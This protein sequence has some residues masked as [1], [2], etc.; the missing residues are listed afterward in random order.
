MTTIDRILTS[1]PLVRLVQSENF[2]GYVYSLSYE[3]ALVISN[4]AWKS[5]VAGIPLNCFLVGATFDPEQ[6]S[7][8]PPSDRE[9]LLLRVIGTASLPQRDDILKAQVDQF[10][11]RERV[12]SRSATDDFDDFTWNEI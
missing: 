9:V 2:I 12:F 10:C 1:D 3:N 7:S 6:F 5:R 8:T 4:D 11:R